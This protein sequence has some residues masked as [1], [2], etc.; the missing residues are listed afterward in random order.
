L[1]SWALDVVHEQPLARRWLQVNLVRQMARE[2]KL[3][4]V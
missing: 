3:G 1:A 2:K 4:A